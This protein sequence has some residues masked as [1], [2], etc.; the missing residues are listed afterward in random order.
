MDTKTVLAIIKMIDARLRVIA[1]DYEQGLMGDTEFYS[2]SGSLTELQ[3]KLQ[4]FIDGELDK[5]ENSTP[6]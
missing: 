6:N 4:S 2:S 5:A 3:N 1:T